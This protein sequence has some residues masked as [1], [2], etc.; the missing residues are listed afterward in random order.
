MWYRTVFA[1]SSV[2][3][4]RVLMALD[5]CI[6]LILLSQHCSSLRLGF[7]QETQFQLIVDPKA[8]FLLQ[9][10]IKTWV[11]RL[12]FCGVTYCFWLWVWA[13]TDL[14]TKLDFPFFLLIK[15]M[16]MTFILNLIGRTGLIHISSVFYTARNLPRGSC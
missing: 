2:R 6:F 5:H 8:W 7:R 13:V 15:A 16:I 14:K 9:V 1:L 12:I 10:G 11:P 3:A 4:L